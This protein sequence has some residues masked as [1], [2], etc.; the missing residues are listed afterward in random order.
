[1]F[2]YPVKN[3]RVTSPFGMRMHM[4]TRNLHQGVDLAS[5][6]RVPIY[7]AADGVVSRVYKDGVLGSYGNVVFIK[8]TIN[9]K[10]YETVYAH[11][12]NYSAKVGQKVSANQQIGM[13]GNT[14]GG[15]SRSTGIH[16]HFE[17][18]TPI[19]KGDKSNAVD[20]LLY[21]SSPE[22]K[23][24]Q[25]LLNKTGA[26]LIVDGIKGSATD[27]AIKT[28]QKNNGLTQDGSVGKLTLAK[29]KDVASKSVVI[30]SKPSTP[31]NT[32]QG[33]YRMFSPSSNTLKQAVEK[34][35]A[36]AIKD[37]LIDAKWLT[38]L[39]AGQLTLDDAFSLKII[40]EQRK[41]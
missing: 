16:L 8:H 22:V 10:S 19:W 20:P 36:Q 35:L 7:S 1:M 27:A 25:E 6:G 37:K 33:G 23:E 12:H 18:N 39:K 24:W 30:S 31:K 34:E 41:K 29:L 11:L 28:F 3:A 32:S 17:V 38:Q 21:L 5:T 26:K 14:D 15:S 40:I 4:G 9:G 13:M 2:E